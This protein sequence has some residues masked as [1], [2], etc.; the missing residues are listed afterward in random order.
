[1]ISAP[2]SHIFRTDSGGS[3][4]SYFSL[5]ENNL[6]VKAG[7]HVPWTPM[8]S[9]VNLIGHLMWSMVRIL[10]CK[11]IKIKKSHVLQARSFL[12]CSHL[13]LSPPPQHTHT[14]IHTHTHTH[15]HSLTHCLLPRIVPRE[16]DWHME[17]IDAD[18]SRKIEKDLGLYYLWRHQ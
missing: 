8:Y 18:H 3:N 14:H 16:R 2:A 1:M 7:V 13:H 11:K 17:F 4:K 6:Y 12:H 10:N 15:T 9:L 5:W